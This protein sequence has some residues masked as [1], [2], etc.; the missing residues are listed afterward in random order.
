LK[1]VAKGY[2]PLLRLPGLQ[3][4]PV[5]DIS[6]DNLFSGQKVDDEKGYRRNC[7]KNCCISSAKIPC[8]LAEMLLCKLCIYTRRSDFFTFFEANAAKFQKKFPKFFLRKLT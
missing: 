3:A 5:A 2:S 1:F 8:R 4:N 7:K 6:A